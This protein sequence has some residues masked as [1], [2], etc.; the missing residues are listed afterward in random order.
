MKNQRLPHFICIFSL[1]I[2]CI[3]NGC[4]TTQVTAEKVLEEYANA[5]GG[6]DNLL[7]KQKLLD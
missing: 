5:I 1:G 3:S 2:G 6:K 7:A 4:T